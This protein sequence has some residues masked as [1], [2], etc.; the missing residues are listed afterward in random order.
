M[1]GPQRPLARKPHL[2]A[3]RSLGGA[4][5][6][7]TACL[8]WLLLQPQIVDRGTNVRRLAWWFAV[9]VGVTVASAFWGLCWLIVCAAS[10][11]SYLARSLASRPG[12]VDGRPVRPTDM[13]EYVGME[14]HGAPAPGTRGL[15]IDFTDDEQA[16]LRVDWMGLGVRSHE[17]TELRRVK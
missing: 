12:R 3:V 1:S 11:D 7:V 13:V 6:V 4:L 14:R 2:G 8:T 5:G 16:S 15:I 9:L 10:D 17:T